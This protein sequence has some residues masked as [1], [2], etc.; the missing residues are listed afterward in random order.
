ME[1][2]PFGFIE[3][4][5]RIPKAQELIL[6]DF[7]FPR[8][9]EGGRKEESS[10]QEPLYRFTLTESAGIMMMSLPE[11]GEGMQEDGEEYHTPP[12]NSSSVP[13]SDEAVGAGAGTV[14]EVERVV[15]LGRDDE[16]DVSQGV[17][18]LEKGGE[19]EK[20][21]PLR[22]KEG[23]QSSSRI[24]AAPDL[25][26][27]CLNS[28]GGNVP[29][30]EHGRALEGKAVFT[31]PEYLARQSSKL[32]KKLGS[33]I[34]NEHNGASDSGVMGVVPELQEIRILK[35][36]D[37]PG[38]PRS[39]N[40]SGR[41]K[42]LEKAMEENVSGGDSDC[43]LKRKTID[44]EFGGS[45]VGNSGKRFVSL[46]SGGSRYMIKDVTNGNT[47]SVDTLESPVR[48]MKFLE[49]NFL[50]ETPSYPIRSVKEKNREFQKSMEKLNLQ[51]GGTVEGSS[52]RRKSNKKSDCREMIRIIDLEVLERSDVPVNTESRR[53]TPAGNKRSM[54]LLPDKS[55]EEI[56]KLRSLE[57][58]FHPHDKGK[59]K[60]L[61][62]GSGMM[63]LDVDDFENC[64]NFAG[65][66]SKCREGMGTSYAGVLGESSKGAQ[67]LKRGDKSEATVP[68]R[69]VALPEE[70]EDVHLASSKLNAPPPPP[71]EVKLPNLLKVMKMIEGTLADTNEGAESLLDIAKQHGMNLPR[72]RWWPEGNFELG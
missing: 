19:P 43:R 48:R 11:T 32:E 49:A 58:S 46:E 72:P 8:K 68:P 30:L 55:V 14:D 25:S 17:S 61:D 60:C 63:D 51:E 56:E 42:S 67:G 62:E 35:G 15:D 36:D 5:C 47:E 7:P 38:G 4:M 27:S 33:V 44:G 20:I 41:L 24:R 31:K 1:I 64:N 45:L 18:G 53:G 3:D 16:V 69:P 52:M 39:A 26:G 71:P 21:R 6:R 37:V 65:M 10:S 59:R 54:D 66:T 28:D 2:D 34:G 22:G 57:K 29:G 13:S 23:S 12:E 40:L 70:D 50:V 9:A